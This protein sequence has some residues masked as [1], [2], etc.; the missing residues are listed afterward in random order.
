MSTTLTPPVTVQNGKFITQIPDSNGTNK[1]TELNFASMLLF[2]GIKALQQNRATFTS[3]YAVAQQRVDLMKTLNEVSQLV[4]KYKKFPDD[5]KRDTMCIYGIKKE[6]IDKIKEGVQ[7]LQAAGVINKGF[8]VDSTTIE[9]KG[10]GEKLD[11]ITKE[12]FSSLEAILQTAQSTLASQNEQQS[13]R[14]NQAM[15]RSSGHLQQLQNLMQTAK[16]SM[17]AAARAGG[18]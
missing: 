11:Y 10:S 4:A 1:N 7:K 9:Q 3:Q 13:M 6:D 16:E 12:V 5:A 17:Q 14:T 8:T 15:N 18:S 2:F